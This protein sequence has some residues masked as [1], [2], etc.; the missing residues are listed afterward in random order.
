LRKKFGH[1]A[2][3]LVAA[4]IAC[5]IFV[6]PGA[7]PA[8]TKATGTPL[9][10]NQSGS[11]VASRNCMNMQCTVQYTMKNGTAFR[12]ICYGDT[13]NQKG[14][15]YSPR[16]FYGYFTLA[17]GGWKYYTF[18]HSSYVYYQVSVPHC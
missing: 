16:W 9:V 8:P 11:T 3:A 17:T 14:N 13:V 6:V 5:G 12:L 7:S 10:W 2:A 18:V 15:Y 4:V 1:F